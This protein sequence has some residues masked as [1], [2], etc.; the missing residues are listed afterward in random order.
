MAIWS[1]KYERRARAERAKVL[2]RA[3]DLV[4]HPGRYTRHTHHGAAAYVRNGAFDVGGSV[5][6]NRELSIDEA[7]VAEA[8]RYDGHYLICTSETGW[9]DA[10][11][12]DA[13]RELWRIEESFRVTKSE[14]EARPVFVWTTQ[15]GR[16]HV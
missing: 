14:L 6:T 13:Y 7:A 11:V 15:I 4:A 5:A 8:E 2:E 1:E 3:R 12:L 10:R 16:A 9:D